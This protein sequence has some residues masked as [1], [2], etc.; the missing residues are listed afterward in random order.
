VSRYEYQ[1]MGIIVY[2]VGSMQPEGGPGWTD[3]SSTQVPH[4][5]GNKSRLSPDHPPSHTTTSTTFRGIQ[6]SVNVTVALKIFPRGVPCARPA[7]PFSFIICSPSLSAFFCAD[8]KPVC[9]RHPS[10][11]TRGIRSSWVPYI[12]GPQPHKRRCTHVG[13]VCTQNDQCLCFL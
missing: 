9:T 6:A 1:S 4:S 12:T 10:T 7:C 5:A 13:P 2:K 11:A 3:P 8:A